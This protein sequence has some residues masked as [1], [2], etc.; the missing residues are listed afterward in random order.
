MAEKNFLFPQETIS[1]QLNGTRK[2]QGQGDVQL[3]TFY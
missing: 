3:M 1:L 2:S